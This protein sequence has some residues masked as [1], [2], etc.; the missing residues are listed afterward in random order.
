MNFRDNRY[1]NCRHS[2]INTVVGNTTSG[3]MSCLQIFTIL[4][5]WPTGV[6]G[7]ILS[8]EEARVE[9]GR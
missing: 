4:S 6:A 7:T 2:K 5:R 1:W 8:S 9:A 3:L